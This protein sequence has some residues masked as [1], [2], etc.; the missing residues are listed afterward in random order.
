MI[1]KKKIKQADIA[2]VRRSPQDIKRVAPQQFT[3]Y[4]AQRAPR[5]D[6]TLEGRNMNAPKV[7]KKHRS[8]ISIRS[9]F[10]SVLALAL[11]VLN[12]RLQ[13][14]PEIIIDGRANASTY[15]NVASRYQEAA[16]GQF[17]TLANSNKLTVNARG[18]ESSLKHQFPE[19]AAVS[20]SLPIIGTRPVVHMQTYQPK[21]M[22]R[23]NNNNLFLIDSLGRA[24]LGGTSAQDMV[25]KQ[26]LNN[27]PVVVDQSGYRIEL[28]KTALPQSTIT[29]ISEA[30]NQLRNKQLDVELAELPS[31][32]SQMVV[33]L[34]G[35]GHTI[36]FNTHGQAREQVGAYLSAK[37]MFDEGLSARPTT[38]IDVRSESKVYYK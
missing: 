9:V 26:E 2:R 30:M 15:A 29:F 23:D 16:S 37:K 36:K 13:S 10:I 7:P 31:N 18:V 32:S 11:V 28:G 25:N 33:K 1:G 19:L 3:T 34:K 22:L 14:H 35:V 5:A 38:Y 8:T 6:A 21:L 20:V 17:G 27:V 4:R 12:T 24:I